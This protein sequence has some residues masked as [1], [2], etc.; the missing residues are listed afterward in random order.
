MKH[1]SETGGA[2]LIRALEPIQGMEFMEKRRAVKRTKGPP[3]KPIKYCSGPSKICMA[4]GELFTY[5]YDPYM[6]MT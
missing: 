1:F 2:V 5:A 6:Y 4:Y 3:L